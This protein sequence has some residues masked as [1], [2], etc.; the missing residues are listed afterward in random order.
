VSD[1]GVAAGRIA[2]SFGLGAL[3]AAIGGIA[4]LP[5]A[6]TPVGAAIA[7]INGCVCGWKGIYDLGSK[8]GW[9]AW[10]RDSTWALPTTG[11]GMAMVGLQ[12]LRSDRNYR[13]SLS[14]RK[15]RIV[16]GGGWRARSGYAT[17]IGPV[18]INA[19][20]RQTFEPGD[21][22]LARRE[23]LVE[24]HEHHH[25]EQARRWGPL[26][27]T[28]YSSWL[29]GGFLRALWWKLRGDNAKLGDL[30][31]TSAYFLN[32]FEK[33]AYRKDEYWPPSGALCHRV[34]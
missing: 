29:L 18:V 31:M 2:E 10:M 12:R 25:V 11:A 4:T 16:Y 33:A 22:R 20:D 28:F 30:I 3:S 14:R 19:F 26:F 8:E 15:N 23:Q 5:L 13:E 24:R 32:P 21:P 17:S 6:A 7:G 1:R 34:R 27:P 9:W